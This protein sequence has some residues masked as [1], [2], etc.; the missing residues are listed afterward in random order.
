MAGIQVLRIE[1]RA[2]YTGALVRHNLR[3]ESVAVPGARRA[4]P[5]G[6]VFE[7]DLGGAAAALIAA[8]RARTGRPP[9]ECLEIVIAGPHPYASPKRW[10][11]E[12]ELAWGVAV[13]AWVKK[14]LGPHTVI[15]VAALHRDE[16]A[17]HVH[18]LAI[19]VDET[20][21]LGWTRVENAAVSRL[22]G[23]VRKPGTKRYRVF[24]DDLYRTVSEPFGL[25]RGKVGSLATHTEVMRTVGLEDRAEEARREAARVEVQARE[26]KK[27]LEERLAD[28]EKLNITA[29]ELERTIVRS[30]EEL[31]TTRGEIESA[32]EEK[33][34]VAS[35]V[36]AF[37]EVQARVEG[38]VEERVEEKARVEVELQAAVEEKARVDEELAAVV[39]HKARVEGEV[40]AVVEH[41]A[42]VDG[43]LEAAVEEKARVDGEVQALVEKKARVEEEVGAV[44]EHK[45]RVDGDLEAAVEEKA[46]VDG[47]V[48]ALVEKKARVEEE[49]GAV[50]EHKARVDGELQ[51]AVEEKDRVEEYAQQVRE[52]A[53]VEAEAGDEDGP[54]GEGRRRIEAA[55]EEA[56][57]AIETRNYFEGELNGVRRV[58]S[59]HA[60]G[61]VKREADIDVL[62]EEA[63][64]LRSTDVA[65]RK[66]V[67]RLE[68]K[69]RGYGNRLRKEREAHL[70]NFDMLIDAVCDARS[71]VRGQLRR[72]LAGETL[73][74]NAEK[75]VERLAL[76]RAQ[77]AFR[78]A[79]RPKLLDRIVRA[80]ARLCKR[81]G[82]PSRPV[83]ASADR[84][85]TPSVLPSGKQRTR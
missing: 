12:T 82:L 68:R 72:H 5:P 35:E 81:L 51:A 11:Y 54:R 62:N 21:R 22:L 37:V 9:N 28:V 52:E 26:G 13:V 83:S 75:Y 7:C 48:Q 80:K 76:P 60:K 57:S 23:P 85:R 59:D 41:K 24:Q 33:A 47:E 6:Y 79:L 74:D 58:L 27:A 40:A 77:T 16:R 4:D 65:R 45:A 53:R 8:S 70:K 39:D 36:E 84:S 3:D 66:Y 55:K 46:R 30:R 18:I 67:A 1:S 61:V 15:A 71:V 20:G 63:R 17:P 78:F 25:E 10:A 38:E 42:R 19:P 43:D 32:V 2:K 64:R 29:G 34:R 73:P 50:V 14:I 31:T 56:R 49:V 44:V 69:L